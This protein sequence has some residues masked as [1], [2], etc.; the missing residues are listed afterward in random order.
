[1]IGRIPP[2]GQSIT[3]HLRPFLLVHKH[4]PQTYTIQRIPR[5]P[6]L[7]QPGHGSIRIGAIRKMHSR[8]PASQMGRIRTRHGIATERMRIDAFQFIVG[9][10]LAP[11][12]QRMNRFGHF[13]ALEYEGR[14]DHGGRAVDTSQSAI[15]SY[16][17]DPK[18]GG[19]RGRLEFAVEITRDGQAVEGWRAREGL[20]VGGMLVAGADGEVVHGMTELL[21]TGRVLTGMTLEVAVDH[22]EG[23]TH[24][25]GFLPIII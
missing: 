17:A 8:I 1:M 16:A 11:F 21:H 7:I 15:S 2:L 6:H 19:R 18:V 23:R 25:Q 24:H 4:T 3:Q 9:D 12:Q 13:V 22:G 5:I 20:G 14:H 10:G